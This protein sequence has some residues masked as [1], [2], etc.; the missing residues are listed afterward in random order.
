M[1]PGW[2]PDA[3]APTPARST[4]TTVAPARSRRWNATE[5]PVIPAPMIAT[6]LT[7]RPIVRACTVD[8]GCAPAPRGQAR[9]AVTIGARRAP[10]A[11]PAPAVRPLPPPP[12]G[13]TP[14]ALPRHDG[15][16]FRVHAARPRRPRRGQPRR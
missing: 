2:T 6:S 4:T 13:R 14:P 16:R 9:D 15:D 11:R 8:A 1:P 7:D 10:P 12:R 5:R 3:P